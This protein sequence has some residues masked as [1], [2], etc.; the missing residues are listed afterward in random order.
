MA[1]RLSSAAGPFDA[2]GA[3]RKSRS[4]LPG[5]LVRSKTIGVVASDPGVAGAEVPVRVLETWMD[6]GSLLDPPVSG[7]AVELMVFLAG[8]G[9]VV[10][11]YPSFEKC[12]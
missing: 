5:D 12:E 1:G 9:E 4:G 11:E 10:S 8:V 6:M 7:I 2:R 3:A